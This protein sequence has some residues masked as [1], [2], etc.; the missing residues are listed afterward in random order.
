MREDEELVVGHTAFQRGAP[1]QM[2]DLALPI[3]PAKCSSLYTGTSRFLSRFRGGADLLRLS[4]LK[5]ET[6]WVLTSV[7]WGTNGVHQTF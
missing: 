1:A 3:F 4:W 2:E 5:D 6:C 7:G